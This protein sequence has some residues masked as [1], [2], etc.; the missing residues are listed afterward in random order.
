MNLATSDYE[1]EKMMRDLII[2]LIGAAISGAF[3]ILGVWSERIRLVKSIPPPFCDCGGSIDGHLL[4]C[5]FK[6]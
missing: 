4:D 5:A 6:I 3:Y 2:A 1:Q